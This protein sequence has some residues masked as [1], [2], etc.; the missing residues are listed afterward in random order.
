M[1][2]R[3]L[4]LTLLISICAT[5]VA[6]GSN[7]DS[8]APAPNA[9]ERRTLL[10]SVTD[11]VIVPGFQRFADS[12]AS[13]ATMLRA[14][15]EVAGTAAAAEQRAAA[16]AAFIEAYRAM[17]YAELL[18]IG[19]YGPG[20][21]FAGGRNIR[22][23]VYSW[24]VTSP[25][26]VDQELV[27]EGYAASDFIE[28]SLPNVFGFDALE[29]LLMYR[30]AE[31]DCPASVWINA[32]EAWDALEGTEVERRRARYAVVVAEQIADDARTVLEAW[33]DGFADSL[34]AAG[35][36]SAIYG[37]SQEGIDAVF[38]SIFYIDTN[39]KD[40]KLAAPLGISAD[41][42]EDTCPDLLESQYANAS[43]LA[44]QDN[45]EAFAD[46]FRGGPATAQDRYG[47]GDLLRESNAEQLADD[48]EAALDLSLSR[49]SSLPDL[50]SDALKTE[51]PVALHSAIKTLTT[52]LKSQ[53]V[54]VL[55]LRV[56]NEGAA[57]ND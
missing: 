52:L 9:E 4:I 26:R 46:V 7:S 33:T 37:T 6:C 1:K 36:G 15:E 16:E 55:A 25:C 32:D 28:T 44:V 39:V 23:R 38:A 5:S 8:S 50:Q 34:R 21:S 2:Y 45:L 20:S 19:P 11:N 35:Q 10:A 17:Q 54:S 12:T 48:L 30:G 3:N 41:C 49:A 14:Y 13:L 18:Q 47:F 43:R 24:P 22:E 51:P 29:Y 42:T 56:P 27:S 31:N 53:F 57:D 40:R